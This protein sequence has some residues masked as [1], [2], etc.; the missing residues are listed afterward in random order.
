[1]NKYSMSTCLIV[2]AVSVFIAQQQF[3]LSQSGMNYTIRND[4][5]D[6]GGS[7]SSSTNY[8]MSDAIGQPVPIGTSAVPGYIESSGFFAGE[9]VSTGIADEAARKILTEFQ[10]CQNYPNPFNPSTT[11]QFQIPMT[12][13]VVIRIYNIKGAVI[14]TLVHG[15]RTA[16]EY[17][18]VWNGNDDRGNLSASGIYL[19]R[20][21]AIVD[22]RRFVQTK[23]LTFIR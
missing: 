16:G 18:A 6:A 14:R 7:I 22:G 12:A 15:K 5:V 13:D 1:M 21:E 17:P 2:W 3:A 11:I 20:M 19:Y 10:L 4:V 23:K 9:G 8:R